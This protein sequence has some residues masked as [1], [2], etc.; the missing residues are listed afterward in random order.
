MFG[1]IMLGGSLLV[2]KMVELVQCLDNIVFIFIVVDKMDGC[3]NEDIYLCGYGELCCNGLVFKGDM[4]DYN[5]DIDVV[6]VIGNVCLFKGGM[7]VIGLDVKFK[8]MVNEGII[9]MFMYEFYMIG[10]YGIVDCIDFIDKDNSCIMCG[11]YIMCLF[12]NVDWYFSVSCIDIDSDCQV[13]IGC[14]GVL[15]FFGV[16]VFVVLIMDFLFND[17]WCS[18]FLVFVF[19]YNSCSGVD[20]M[21]LYYFNFVLNCDLML[22]LCLLS[23]CGLQF[24]VEYC[25]F[26]MLYSGVLCGE[27]LFDDCEVGCNCWLILVLYIQCLVFGL[28]GYINYNKVFDN[29]YLDD[30]GCS[31]VMVMQCQYIQ[32]GGV[33]YLFG[34]WVVMV[35]VQ[36]FQ[37]LLI[38]IMLLVVLY[39]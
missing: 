12:D 16:L 8:V 2:F 4:F 35:C 21:L 14:N 17:D 3:I 29:I 33:I 10:G 39:E 19:G 11:M 22:Y 30:L 7:F 23:Q 1:L 38:V 34:D 6:I 9:S 13:G 36:K 5:Q 18:G 26:D 31:I 37:M 20:V 32:E 25:Y 15:Y 27:F 28:I 24:G